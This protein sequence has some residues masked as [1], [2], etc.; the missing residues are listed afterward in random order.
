MHHIII[1]G[2]TDPTIADAF[3]IRDAVF[4]QEQGYAAEIDIDDYDD[5][6]HHVIVYQDDQA[7]ATARLILLGDIGKIGRVAVLKSHRGQGIGLLLMQVLMTQAK[8]LPITSLVLS[9]QVHAIAFY[10]KLGFV[11]EGEIYLEDGEPHIHMV[12]K[13]A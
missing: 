2:R 13:L 5:I 9:S 1:K 12:K 10:E 6:A 7:I 4:T 8:Q 3:A 11:T